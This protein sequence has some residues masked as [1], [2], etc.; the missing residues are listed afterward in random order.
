M[1]VLQERPHPVDHEQDEN[2]DSGEC[3]PERVGLLAGAHESHDVG[4]DAPRGDI[5]DGGAGNGEHSELT[6]RQTALGENAGQ[7]GKGG[8][9]HGRAE[10]E[11]KRGKGDV[12]A[13]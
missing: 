11:S 7:H 9:A 1:E 13:G 5:I 2:G 4:Q 3:D 12:P 6:A 8:D 10:K